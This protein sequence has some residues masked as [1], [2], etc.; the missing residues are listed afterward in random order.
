MIKFKFFLSRD[1]QHHFVLLNGMLYNS[2]MASASE[3]TDMKL[4]GIT[5]LVHGRSKIETATFHVHIQLDHET[6]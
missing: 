4:G 6:Q 5:V 3:S 2:D 1:E